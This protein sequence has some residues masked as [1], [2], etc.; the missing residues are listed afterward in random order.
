MTNDR[1]PLKP[2]VPGELGQ[3]MLRAAAN[4]QPDDAALKRTLAALGTVGA[5][6]TASAAVQGMSALFKWGIGAGVCALLA[7]GGI[8]LEHAWNRPAMTAPMIAQSATWPV[9]ALPSPP[10]PAS[11]SLHRTRTPPPPRHPAPRLP[12]PLRRARSPR[13]RQLSSLSAEV[14]AMDAARATLNRGDAKGCLA[15]LDAYQRSFPRGALSQEATVMRIEALVRSGDRAGARRLADWFLPHDRV[16]PYAA[17]I[18]SL[19]G[20]VSNP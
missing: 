7:V 9:D 19:V 17:R 2:F 18:H 4:E 11:T 12:R 13:G 16:S 8:A 3:A 1:D 5:I 15:A 10:N 14:A 20:D 6:T